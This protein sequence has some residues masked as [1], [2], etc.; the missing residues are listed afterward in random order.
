MLGTNPTQIPIAFEHSI[1]PSM[2]D[3]LGTL[4]QM[5]QEAIAAHTHTRNRMIIHSKNLTH[6]SNL[7]NKCG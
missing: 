5:R 7:D 6:P 2:E 4:V 1:H 3:K